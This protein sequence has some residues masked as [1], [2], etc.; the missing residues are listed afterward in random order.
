[1]LYLFIIIQVKHTTIMKMQLE[2]KGPYHFDYI[3]NL[4]DLNTP[5]IYI[6]GFT[7]NKKVKEYAI[8][9]LSKSNNKSDGSLENDKLF[10]PYYVGIASGKSGMTL[11]K[12]LTTHHDICNGNRRNYTRLSKGYL[13]NIKSEKCFSKSLLSNNNTINTNDIDYFNNIGFLAFR[14]PDLSLNKIYENLNIDQT[15]TLVKSLKKDVLKSFIEKRNN[16][17]F[18]Y[19]TM[20]EELLTDK[21]RG[22]LN[23]KTKLGY[24]ESYV[25]Y[26]L[27]GIT[28]SNCHNLSSLQRFIKDYDIEI[29]INSNTLEIFKANDVFSGDFKGDY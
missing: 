24:L 3:G 9:D 6:W 26:S 11:R 13:K 15:I 14:Y 12:R 2:F 29:K 28:I 7:A 27:R 17:S 1:M 16:F 20:K 21:I 10:I 4:N 18:I 5:G 23:F 22:P 19:C 8:E 25:F